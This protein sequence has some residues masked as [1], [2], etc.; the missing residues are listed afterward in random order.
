[1]DA[2]SYPAALVTARDL[3]EQ[4]HLDAGFGFEYLRGMV[5]LL[6]DCFGVYELPVDERMDE[7]LADLRRIPFGADPA[8]LAQY[9]VTYSH[10]R[11]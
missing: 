11:Q 4:E 2:V 6:A 1:V 5:N 8:Q 9:G 10:H 7:V 3:I